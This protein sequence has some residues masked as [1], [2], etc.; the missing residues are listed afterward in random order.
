[1]ARDIHNAIIPVDFSDPK[2]VMLVVE[3]VADFVKR[4][5]PIRFGLVPITQTE[6]ATSQAKVIYHLLDTYGISALIKYLEHV[7]PLIIE[8]V[9]IANFVVFVFQKD[10]ISP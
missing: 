5:I 3:T 4:K 7:R 1:V 10:S 2:H 6:Q 8:Y 9:R